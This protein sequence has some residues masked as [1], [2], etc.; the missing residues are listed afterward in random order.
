VRRARALLSYENNTKPTGKVGSSARIN[1]FDCRLKR[2]A[3][4]P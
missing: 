1:G 3:N 4:R 2:D